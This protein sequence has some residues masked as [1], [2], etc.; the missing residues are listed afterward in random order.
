MY[1]IKNIDFG[2][3]AI[4]DASCIQKYSLIALAL[5]IP[6]T[7]MSLKK[8]KHLT[9]PLLLR[10]S[11][12]FYQRSDQ[13][14]LFFHQSDYIFQEISISKLASFILTFGGTCY[15]CDN[16]YPTDLLR[17]LKVSKLL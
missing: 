1:A 17:I 5:L 15:T 4:L 10:D 14:P 6:L 8:K 11:G 13:L 3:K 2:T 12:G 16:R 7:T 9:L